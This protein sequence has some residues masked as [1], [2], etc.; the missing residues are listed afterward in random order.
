MHGLLKMVTN[1]LPY[2]MIDVWEYLDPE[3]RS[4]Y[5]AWFNRLV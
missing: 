2:P 5:A 1:V 3:G 4:P